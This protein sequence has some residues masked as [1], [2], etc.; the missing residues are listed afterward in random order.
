MANMRDISVGPVIKLQLISELKKAFYLH[1]S[2]ECYFGEYFD[3]IL[4]L[5]NRITEY[6]NNFLVPDHYNLHLC[7][8]SNLPAHSLP[9]IVNI[10]EH[11]CEQ[12]PDPISIRFQLVG[13]SADKTTA[14]VIIT[15]CQKPD[16]PNSLRDIALW[17]CI[18]QLIPPQTIKEYVGD[19]PYK[20]SRI[21]IPYLMGVN[22]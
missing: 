12:V 21:Y 4:I 9:P 7:P 5:P 19:F 16:T 15:E 14:T 22:D 11:E 6:Y 17:K 8:Q 3:N 10:Y 13:T 18:S 20:I 2:M 1:V